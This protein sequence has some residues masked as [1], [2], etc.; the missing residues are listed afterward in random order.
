MFQLRQQLI[1]HAGQKSAR[2]ARVPATQ[3]PD[4]ALLLV[5]R[6]VVLVLIALLEFFPDLR[7][8]ALV[9]GVFEDEDRG[10]EA[11]VEADRVDLGGKVGEGGLDGL[12]SAPVGDDVEGFADDF[13]AAGHE[14]D[15][16]VGE[17]G[18]L[19]DSEEILRGEKQSEMGKMGMG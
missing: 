6:P 1:H 17:R 11:S 2:F 18:G 12:V 5:E 7:V 10:F 14:I 4:E 3:L 19:D 15:A 8:P 13:L 9:F 16:E